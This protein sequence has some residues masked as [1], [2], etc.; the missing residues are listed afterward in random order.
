MEIEDLLRDTL[1]DVAF[2]D[3]QWDVKAKAAAQ[4]KRQI[5]GIFKEEVADFSKYRLAKAF[6]RW[7]RTKTLSDLAPHEV[8]SAESLI[9]AI[10]SALQPLKRPE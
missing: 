6:L 1:I 5:T 10:E 4:P 7:T 3:L 8:T 2:D 9:A